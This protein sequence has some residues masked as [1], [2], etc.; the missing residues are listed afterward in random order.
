VTNA[1][2]ADTEVGVWLDAE[3]GVKAENSK[4]GKPKVQSGDKGA[5]GGSG[6]LAYRPGWHLGEIPYALQFNR[7]E[8]VDNPL[9]IKNQNDINSIKGLFFKDIN[10]IINWIN[11]GLLVYVNKK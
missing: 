3:E 1:G 9:G 4:P 7:G 2:G 11:N 8:K 10:K 5:Q 6:T